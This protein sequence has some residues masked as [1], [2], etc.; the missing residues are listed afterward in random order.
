MTTYKSVATWDRD[1]RAPF[2]A[3]IAG[4]ASLA[5]WSG[6]IVTGRLIAYNWF[7]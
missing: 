4:M 2:P 5:L 1:L 6:I 3:R 7:Q